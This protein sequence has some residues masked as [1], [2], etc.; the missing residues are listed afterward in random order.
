MTS[1]DPC[2]TQYIL[3]AR[4]ACVSPILM[5]AVEA[6]NHQQHVQVSEKHF[7]IVLTFDSD[8]DD[9]TFGRASDTFLIGW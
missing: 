3:Y 4:L 1:E 6:I 9:F 7:K 5:K 8:I 2:D